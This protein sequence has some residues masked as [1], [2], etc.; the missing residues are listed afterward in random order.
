MFLSYSHSLH[1]ANHTHIQQ[2]LHTPYS[3]LRTQCV[4][5]SS[6]LYCNMYHC[7]LYIFLIQSTSQLTKVEIRFPCKLYTLFPVSV[8]SLTC[9]MSFR[10]NFHEFD[11][12]LVL[13]FWWRSYASNVWHISKYILIVWEIR[14]AFMC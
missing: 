3:L 11:T 8:I 2:I 12:S 14:I 10:F 13:V 1:K 5:L 6:M 7:I 9:F 4:C